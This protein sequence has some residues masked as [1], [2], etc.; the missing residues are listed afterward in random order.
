VACGMVLAAELSQRLGGVDRSFVQ[1]LTRLIAAAGLPTQAP[2]MPSERWLEL[3]R[4][5]KK[6]SAGAI[7]FV[8]ISS[9][10]RAELQRAPDALVAEVIA[11]GS[12][13]DS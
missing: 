4:V 11:Q 1:R 7:R 10:G 6:A 12:S 3:M 2:P 9:P 5:D 13:S 8:V